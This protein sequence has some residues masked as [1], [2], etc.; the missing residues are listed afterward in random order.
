MRPA[1]IVAIIIG[2]LLI[3]IGLALLV[4]GSFLWW[5]HGTA[6]SQGYLNTSER[7]IE[8][9]GHALVTP[10]VEL[11]LG[12]WIPGNWAVQLQ[13]TSTSDA[14]VFLGVGPAGEVADYLSGVP[15]DEV[16][17]LGWFS[18]GVRYEVTG[19]G[20]AAPPA[21]PGEQTFWVAEQEGV[22]AQTLQWRIRSGNWTAV[23]MN[24]DGSA[25][26]AADVSLGARLGFLLPLGVG[27]TVGGVV[28]LAV[29]ILLV[30]LGARRSREPAQPYG[31]GAPY[32]QP[33][34]AQP[35]YG[36]PPYGHPPYGPNAP[37]PVAPPGQP[38]S[39]EQAPPKE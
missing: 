14:P 24:A 8:S 37:P 5:L 7:R 36:Q 2:V 30:V 9:G 3:I 28:L 34:Y 13:A 31:P 17:N 16:T 15:Y 12:D 6:D 38:V 25:P 39:P 1:K 11:E 33:P 21:P 27:L 23:L 22:G 32:G 26:V 18:S 20:S 29:G 4:P 19:G 10:D 35:P